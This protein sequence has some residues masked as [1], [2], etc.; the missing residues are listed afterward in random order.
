MCPYFKCVPILIRSVE[1]VEKRQESIII[2]EGLNLYLTTQNI[3]VRSELIAHIV[4]SEDFF[5]LTNDN[6]LL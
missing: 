3:V 2:M 4:I 1:G 6:I 5:P